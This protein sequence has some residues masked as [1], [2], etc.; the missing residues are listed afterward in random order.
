ME[1]KYKNGKDILLSLLA[2]LFIGM[3]VIIPGISGSAL[4]MVLKVYDKMMYA[5]SNLFKKFKACFV[6][7]L[8]IVG[9]IVVGFLAGLVL[10]KF[11]L[12]RYPFITMCLFVGLMLGTIPMLF[13]EVKGEKA[14][15][16]RITLLVVGAIVPLAITIV[17]M[18]AGGN[19]SLETIEPW[20]YL[21]FLG[22]GVLVS[23]T[24][25]VP[26]LSATVLLMIFGYYSALIAGINMDLFSNVS[27]VFVYL[28]LALG[29][30][31]GILLFSKLINKI[32]E[33]ARVGFYYLVCGLSTSSA[34][35]V[36][37][38]NDCLEIYKTWSGNIITRDIL[39]GIV[40]LA[41]GF[42]ITFFIYIENKKNNKN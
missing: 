5:F 12:E 29:F 22:I 21:V 30:V 32:L 24:Q 9:G 36:F 41:L 39:L 28:S 27:L 20:Q 15:P 19:N 26:G 6:F 40:M 14:S 33:K 25:L 42:G 23:L 2:G 17:S 37:L 38:G 10:V 35:S 11:L 18:F 1:L 16:S 8:P 31:V 4:A 7:L 3:S 13:S 34:I